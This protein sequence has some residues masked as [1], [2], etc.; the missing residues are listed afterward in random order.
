M[1]L[2]QNYRKRPVKADADAKAKKLT[3]ELK[4]QMR[5]NADAKAN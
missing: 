4:L 2:V 1:T 3:P 5:T